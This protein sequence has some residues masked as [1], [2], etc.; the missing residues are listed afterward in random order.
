MASFSWWDEA[1]NFVAEPDTD[2][3]SENIDMM[4]GTLEG[5]DTVWVTTPDLNVIHQ[6]DAKYR[7]R[8]L[9]VNELELLHQLIADNY[10]FSYFINLDG[11][12]WEI[13]GA[14]I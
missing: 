6:A 11:E 10:E 9:P 7:S 8:P 14:A 5:G 1:V 12:L 4:V 13:F 3:A 2:W